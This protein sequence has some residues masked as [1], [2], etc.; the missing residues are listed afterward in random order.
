MESYVSNQALIY[1]GFIAF[2]PGMLALEVS[3][4]HRRHY[5]VSVRESFVWTIVWIV[6]ALA[7][8]AFVYYRYETISPG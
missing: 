4:F 3:A 5:V 1:G 8:M 7:F 2:V 6:L